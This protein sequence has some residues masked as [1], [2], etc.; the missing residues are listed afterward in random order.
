[1]K[2]GVV[3]VKLLTEVFTEVDLSKGDVTFYDT[4]Y[5]QG[6]S[7]GAYTKNTATVYGGKANVA[8]TPGTGEHTLIMQNAQIKDLHISDAYGK[9][10]EAQ[11]SGGGR[12]QCG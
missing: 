2:S 5:K 9:D 10:G 7:T 11:P 6:N 1:M 4:Y 3:S 8:Y 12:R